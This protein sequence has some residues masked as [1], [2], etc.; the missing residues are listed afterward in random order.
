[1]A[2]KNIGF[3]ADLAGSAQVRTAEG[4][5]KVL[6]IGDSVG[7]RDLLITGQGANVV[8][9]FNSGQRLQVG[10]SAQVLLDESVY[11]DATSY[12]DDQVDQLAELQQAILE[13]KDLSELEPTAAGNEQGQSSGLH[14]T[15]I[16]ERDAREGD[17]ETRQTDINVGNNTN[18]QQLFINDDLVAA[19]ASVNTP[20]PTPTPVT[21]VI[22]VTNINDAPTLTVQATANVAEDGLVNIT[23]A[24]ADV[25]GTIVSTVVNVDPALG[26]A[27]VNANGTITFTPTANFNGDATVT[28]VTTDNDGATATQ[29]S[30]ITVSD[31]NDAPTLTVQSVATTS[32]DNAVSITYAAADVDGTIVSTIATVDPAQGT[33]VVN[34]NGT[35]TFTP[36]TNFNGDATV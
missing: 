4:V 9:A 23:Y 8:I 17:V 15:P 7:D 19:D 22:P 12:T 1:M 13:G 25:D 20:A 11:D 32:E 18:E 10:E 14:Q 24:A 31:V 28:V 27:V 29:T 21:P 36:A 34:A 6:N 30:I 16:Y 2:T 26:T 5:I 33:A 3:I 35:I